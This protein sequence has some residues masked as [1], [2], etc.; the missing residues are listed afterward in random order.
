MAICSSCSISYSKVGPAQRTSRIAELLAESNAPPEYRDSD[1]HRDLL[2]QRRQLEI[3]AKELDKTLETLRARFQPTLARKGTVERDLEDLKYILRPIR[4]LPVEVLQHV[5]VFA[6]DATLSQTDVESPYFSSNSLS[7]T[8]TTAPWNIS[9]ICQLWRKATLSHPQLWAY[10]GL[11]IGGAPD[12]RVWHLL[13]IQLSRAHTGPLFVSIGSLKA[14]PPVLVPF[15]MASASRW[16]HVR[17][18]LYKKARVGVLMPLQPFLHGV[19]ALDIR[20]ILPSPSP[21]ALAPIHVFNNATQLRELCGNSKALLSLAHHSSPPDNAIAIRRL[22]LEGTGLSAGEVFRKILSSYTQVEELVLRW[23]VFTIPGN[24][25]LPITL[26]QLRRLDLYGSPIETISQT[27]KYMITPRLQDLSVTLLHND[28]DSRQ[29]DDFLKQ[30]WRTLRSLD[31]HIE[32][33]TP[34]RNN[35]HQPYNIVTPL[36]QCLELE[37]LVLEDKSS[38][39]NIQKVTSQIRRKTEFLPKLTALC[40]IDEPGL[41]LVI[42]KETLMDMRPN[43]RVFFR[44]RKYLKTLVERLRS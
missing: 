17:L 24:V 40:L 30:S 15:L 37:L 27:L 20:I 11:D 35:I 34:D 6:R 3:E 18:S 32:Y 9:Q 28:F 38:S 31:L 36:E 29:L 7:L 14:L 8:S 12:G 42:D 21:S 26:A 25:P 5:F 13:G 33:N 22:V 23:D 16:K 43:L 44:P 41:L 4:R 19:E 39:G 2:Q 1:E 10:I